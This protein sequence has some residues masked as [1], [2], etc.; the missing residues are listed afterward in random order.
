MAEPALKQTPRTATNA[1]EMTV[2]ELSGAIKRALEVEG[3][4]RLEI[5]VKDALKRGWPRETR[6]ERQDKGLEPLAPQTTGKYAK[7]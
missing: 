7:A 1:P 2:S 6:L 5:D 4:G 3:C